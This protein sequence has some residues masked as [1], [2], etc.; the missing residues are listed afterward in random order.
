[1]G[2]FNSVLSVILS[3]IASLLFLTVLVVAH[4]FGHFAVG[5]RLGFGIEEFSVGFGPKL[6]QKK[7]KGIAYS[8]RLL[9]LGGY[10][11]FMGEDED[12]GAADGRDP[13]E[14]NNRPIWQRAL[15]IAAGPVM[16]ILFAFV[17][18]L[19]VLIGFG[20]SAPY[21]E[22]VDETMPAY[23][24]GLRP[25][26]RVA[27]VGDRV[28]DFYTEVTLHPFSGEVAKAEDTVNV[29]VERDGELISYDVP[30]KTMEDGSRKI[31][32][33]CN[34]YRRSFGFFDAIAKS[35]KWMYLMISQ[36]FIFLG[37]LIFKGQ[38]V[39]D[40]TGPVGTVGIISE[41]ITMG[42]EVIMRLASLI[43]INLAVINIL[44]LPALDGGRLAFLGLEKITGNRIPKKV[45][46][47]VNFVGIILLFALMIPLT[48]QDI[49]RLVG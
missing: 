16:N 30:L 24:V 8:V 2:D 10:V 33:A 31:G 19:I 18:T 5:K 27:Q 45:E 17:L 34:I 29:T 1:M 9:P 41:Y 22:T 49:S 20:D 11:R 36:M 6:I 28:Y 13:R 48:V 7:R 3:V 26:D 23:E 44:P 38:G 43:S 46:G 12:T 4:E 37:N 25:G 32:M 21:I 35:F 40:V 15:T 47:I 42:G 39:A 14:F